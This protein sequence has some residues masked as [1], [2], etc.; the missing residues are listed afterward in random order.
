MKLPT[1]LRP[2]LLTRL[3]TFYSIVVLA[4]MLSA[5]FPSAIFAQD[6][7]TELILNGTM[8]LPGE[9]EAANVGGPTKPRIVEVVGDQKHGGENSLH[10]VSERENPTDFPQV[11]S[12]QFPTE[13]GTR[14]KISFWYKILQ[15]G[16]GVNMRNGADND[17]VQLT[18]TP[19]RETDSWELFEVEYEEKDGGEGARFTIGGI[20]DGLCEIYLD[21]V[22]VQPIR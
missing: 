5:I 11:T 6:A 4:L 14:Y 9:W 22:S 1:H 7:G 15:G 3:V 13:T 12:R 21:D 10:I 2:S 19:L 20:G 17:Y 16:F 8:E 18:S